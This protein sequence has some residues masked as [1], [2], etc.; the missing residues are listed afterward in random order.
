MMAEL[1]CTDEAAQL[2]AV[3]REVQRAFPQ[4]SANQVEAIVL[5]HW[6]EFRRARVR[7]LIPLFVRRR[8]IAELRARDSRTA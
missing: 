7:D 6:R 3:T 2:A 1:T 4:T 8:A 5:E